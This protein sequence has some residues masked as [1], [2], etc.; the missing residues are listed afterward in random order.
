MPTLVLP[1]LI[2]AMTTINTCTVV[3]YS[4]AGSWL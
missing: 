3:R 4:A 2:A 1:N